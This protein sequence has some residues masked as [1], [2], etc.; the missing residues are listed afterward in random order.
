MNGPLRWLAVL[1]PLFWVQVVHAQPCNFTANAGPTQYTICEGASQQLNGSANN[2][3]QP[4]SYSWSPATGLSN[5]NVANPSASP[6]VTTVYT[7]TVTDDNNCTATDSITINVNPAPPA[8][9]TT[10]GPEQITTFNNLTTFSICDPSGSWNFSFTDQSA[11]VPGAVRSIN[12]GDG[13]PVENPSQGWSLSH[14]YAQGLWTMTYTIAYPNGCIR[15]QQY[16]VFLGTNPGGGISTDPNTNICTGGTLPFYINSVAGNSPGTTYIINFGDGNSVTLAHPPPAVVNHTYTTSTCGLAGGQLNV[17]FTAQN[18]CDQTQG[19]IGPIRVS[20]TPQAQFTL[21]PNDTACVNTTVSFTDQSIGLTAPGCATA[22][23]NIWSVTPSTGWNIASGTLGNDNG[24]PANPGLWTDGSTTLNLQFTVAG[25]YTITDLTG[26]S[27]GLHTLSRTICV[28]EPPVPAFTLS[29]N[30]GCVPL[31]VTTTN[32]TNSPNSC[33]TTWQWNVN[34]T[35]SSCATGTATSISSTAFQPSFLFDQPGT[36]T[37]QFRAVNTCNVPPITQQVV[38]NAPP[39]VSTAALS[40]ICAGQCVNPSATVQDCGAP[41][42]SY[43]WNFPGGTPANA[44]TLAPGQVCFANAGNP[45]LSLTVVNACGQATS[46]AN[47]SIGTA[48]AAPAASSNS[49]VCAGQTISFTANGGAGVSYIWTGPGGNVVSNQAAFTI[50]NASAANAGQYTVVAV[51]NGCQSPATIVNVLVVAAPTVSVTPNTAAVCNGGSATFTA[52]GAGNY[53]WYIGSTQVGTGPTFTATPTVTTTY[54]VTGDVGGCPGNTTVTM[55]VYQPTPTTAGTAQTF[56]D[57]AIPVTLAGASPTGGTWSGPLVTAGGVFTPIPDSLGV[58]VLTY[59]YVNANGCTSTAQVPITVQDVPQFANAGA[60]TTLCQGT[61]PVQLQGSSPAGGTWTGAAAGGWYTPSATGNF[62]LTYAYGTGT[63]ATSDQVQVSVVPA[64]LLNVMPAFSLCADAAAVA[65]TGTPAGGNWTGNGVSGPPWS[66]DPGA[67]APG[68]Q[69]LTY[70]YQNANG[71]VSTATLNATVNAI[72]SVNAGPDLVLC[73]QPI[74]F[75]LSGS[76]VGGTWSAGWMSIN[77]SNELL[78]SGVGSDVITYTLVDANGCTASDQ[79]TVDVQPVIDPANAGAD[80]AVCVGSGP[81]QLNATPV[82]GTWSGPQVSPAGVL[83]TSVAGSYTLTYSIGTGTCLLQDQVNVVVNDLPVVDAGN[84]IAV[85]LDGGVQV[86]TATP[87][88]GTWS[89]VGV[90]PITGEFDPLL[91]LPGGNPVT[92]LYTDPASGCSNSDGATVTVQPLPVADFTNGPVAC[93]GVSFGF[94]NAS[95]GATSAEWDFGDGGVSFA[96]SPQHTYTT[97]GIYTVRL[98]AITGAGCS[99]TTYSTVQVWDVPEAQLALSTDEGCGPLTVD[100]DNT[101]L[102]DGLT[103]VWDFGGLGS[104]TDQWPG[105]FTFPPDPQ[106]AAVY[107]VTLTATNACGADSDSAPVTVIPSPTAVFGPNVNLHCAYSDVPFGNASYGLPDTFTWDFGDGGTS[108]DPGP[109]VTHAYLVDVDSTVH[110]TITLVVANQC[111]SDTAQQVIGVVPNE[112]TAFF[113]TDPVVGCGPLTVDLTNYSSGDTALLWSFGD[114]NFSIADAPS[115][116]FVNAGTYV[117][118]LSAFGC[119]FDQYATTVT[120]LPSPAVSFTTTPSTVCAGEPFTFTNTTPNSASVSWDFGDGTGSLLSAPEHAYATGGTYAV[121]LTVT[122]A[123]DGCTATLVQQVTVGTTPV[124]SFTPQPGSGCIDL[125]VNFANSSTGADFYQ[126]DF[127][128]GNT[129][130]SSTPTHTYTT[131]DTYSVTLVAENLNGCTDTLSMPVVAFP[132]PTSAFELSAYSSCTSPVTVQTINNSQSA[133]G[134]AWDLGNGNTSVLNE[135]SITFDGPGTYTVSLTSTNQYGCEHVAT[136]QFIV[137][138]T[139]DASFT[140]QPQ[141][142]CARY[143][144]QFINT[145]VNAQSYQWTLGDGSSSQA[146]APQHTYANEGS[147]SVTLIATG[148]GGCADTLVVPGAVLVHPTPTAAFSTDTVANVRNAVR[149]NNESQG[150]VN[151]N[152][153]FGDATTSTDVHPLHLYPADGGPFTTCLVAINELG[154][155]DTTCKLIGVRADPLVYVPNAFSPNG[156][157]RNEGFRPV[158]NGF[159]TWNYTLLIF[160]RWGKEIYRTTDRE[161]EWDGRVGGQETVIDVYV[162]KVI[163][164]RDGDARDFVGHVTL[165]Q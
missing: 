144:L 120:V 2:G 4:Y 89:G 160:D 73:D 65:L 11:N 126:W 86:L 114:G 115:H 69:V 107:N 105:S 158:L 85:C 9:L 110:Y 23:R 127:G 103:Y 7:L 161:A 76:P 147:Y 67:V 111:G 156:D 61:T 109:I 60:D 22:P 75:P 71:C 154:C 63:C 13:S 112:V 53:Q 84:D 34:G 141:P 57:Q 15:S 37:V 146:D 59:T 32:S 106:Q 27:C 143:P 116:T 48:P 68:T 74:P 24:N 46:N 33:Q 72:P 92:Y 128:D 138:P 159:S 94:A 81:L 135:P 148:A 18:P 102:G 62:T 80:T 139:P 41:I 124:A 101:S 118:E 150:A 98:V 31:N 152:W 44:N 42:T 43:T 122:S 54:T 137:H 88:G 140:L 20:E 26:N 19:Q 133:I 28:E 8:L 97:T 17:T 35:A 134:Y 66:F 6:T 45:T 163:V 108:S 90:D 16:Q 82:G 119:G 87:T 70:T 121:S 164:E 83:S 52:S 99:D 58:F 130:G 64:T 14:N 38:V 113:N 131:A 3:Q 51:S 30:T 117:I 49:P 10:T 36:Y 79:A 145:S 142:A 25:T 39:Q 77:A 93:A 96:M 157:G 136:Q 47:L 5:P 123:P 162:W 100:P 129:A 125:E 12:W 1:V 153:D 50:P 55:T 165:V 132:L 21:A 104:S 149:F 78:P 95:I 151:Y 91:A 155:P 56:C 29:A 40:G